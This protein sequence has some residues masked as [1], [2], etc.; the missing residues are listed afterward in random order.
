MGEE[1]AF[2]PMRKRI[3]TI[4][5][6]ADDPAGQTIRASIR[7]LDK[8]NRGIVSQRIHDEA[9]KLIA[10]RATLR[11]FRAPVEFHFLTESDSMKKLVGFVQAED[12]RGRKAAVRVVIKR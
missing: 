1:K 8:E 2:S 9:F 3:V 7:G 4:H 6:D 10:W 12:A 5:V 11:R